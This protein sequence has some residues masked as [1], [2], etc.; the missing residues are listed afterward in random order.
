MPLYIEYT[1]GSCLAFSMTLIF[2]ISI[3]MLEKSVIF[4]Q[5]EFDCTYIRCV[6]IIQAPAFLIEI[7]EVIHI[8]ES[9]KMLTRHE[10]AFV[11]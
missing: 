1:A 5:K 3:P 4:Q 6:S 7:S 11:I 9:C 2:I 8:Q 10:I